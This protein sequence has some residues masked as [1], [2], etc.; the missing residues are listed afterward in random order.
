MTSL[1]IGLL[2]Q[3]SENQAVLDMIFKILW[4]FLFIYELALK[5]QI[6]IL[7]SGLQTGMMTYTYTHI[8]TDP[9]VVLT[10]F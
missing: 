1:T 2:Q 6:F 3:I 5:G 8:H 10:T 9:T 4:L 7:D